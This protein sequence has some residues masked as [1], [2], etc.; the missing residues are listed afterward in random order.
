MD[1]NGLSQHK[2]FLPN[3]RN[4]TALQSYKIYDIYK[5]ISYLINDILC[6]NR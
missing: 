4:N 1:V 3:S 5:Q 6:V 2:F